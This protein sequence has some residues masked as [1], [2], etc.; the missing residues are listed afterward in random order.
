MKNLYSVKLQ[1]ILDFIKDDTIIIHNAEFDTNF[2]NKLQFGFNIK[3]S[4][5]DTIKMQKKNFWTDGK[6]R[7]FIK[8][9]VKNTRQISWNFVRCTLLSKVYLRLTTGKQENFNLTNNKTVNINDNI[10]DNNFKVSFSVPRKKLMYLS[11]YE[12]KNHETFIAEMTDPL[13]KKLK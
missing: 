8:L 9:G 5:I 2:I 4:V 1:K 7:F 12:K 3:N 10:E 11:D 6:F 13:W